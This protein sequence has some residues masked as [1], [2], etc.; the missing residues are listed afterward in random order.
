MDDNFVTG[1]DSQFFLPCLKT[2]SLRSNE[3]ECLRGI[4]AMPQL[5]K[6][7]LSFNALMS[8]E[9]LSCLGALESL[10]ALFVNDNPMPYPAKEVAEYIKRRCPQIRL[11]NNEEIRRPDVLRKRYR[12]ELRST[13]FLCSSLIRN[14]SYFGRLTKQSITDCMIGDCRNLE[15]L[16]ISVLLERGQRECCNDV[17]MNEMPAATVK[18]IRKEKENRLE[19]ALWLLKEGADLKENVVLFSDI[20]IENTAKVLYTPFDGPRP[21]MDIRV[22]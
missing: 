8:R 21:N 18:T 6:L 19:N 4:E 3:V 16:S 22:G 7:D 17:L 13:Q 2:L 15:L 1:L 20:E 10:E 9:E 11:L 5:R 12:Y 14:Q